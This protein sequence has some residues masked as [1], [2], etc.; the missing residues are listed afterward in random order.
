MKGLEMSSSQLRSTRAIAISGILG[1]MPGVCSTGLE[2]DS[3]TE[4]AAAADRGKPESL[5]FVSPVRD[6]AARKAIGDCM[7]KA[8]EARGIDHTDMGPSGGAVIATFQ[9]DRIQRAIANKP[10]GFKARS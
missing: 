10:D 1:L 8:A 4:P 9:L 7:R 3:D 5:V 2:D 6:Y